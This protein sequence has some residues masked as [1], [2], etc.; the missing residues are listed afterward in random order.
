MFDLEQQIAAW[1]RNLERKRVANKE[2][3]TELEGHLRDHIARLKSSGLSDAERFQ[4]AIERMGET[5]ALKEEFAKVGRRGFGFRWGTERALNV[6]GVWFILTGLSGLSFLPP[7][8]LAGLSRN[9]HHIVICL[10]LCGLQVMIGVGILRRNN[11]SRF[12]ALGWALFYALACGLFLNPMRGVM[13]Y[14]VFYGFNLPVDF[15]QRIDSLRRWQLVALFTRFADFRH[16]T[17]FLSPMILIWAVYFLTRPAARRLFNA[18]NKPQ[19]A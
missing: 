7:L 10:C 18:G 15:V 3:L 17:D 8:W 16:L 19:T 12:G 14:V 6:I 13:G 4:I 2:A 11:L 1:R 5:T 9:I